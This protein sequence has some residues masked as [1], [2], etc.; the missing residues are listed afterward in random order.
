MDIEKHRNGGL[1]ADDL[2]SR[3]N[4]M[5]TIL[6]AVSSALLCVS[7]VPSTPQAR[8]QR[9]PEKFSALSAK[10]RGLVEQGK[11]ARGMPRDAVYLAWGSPSGV[12]QGT[13]ENKTTERWDYSGSRPVYMTGFYGGYGYGPYG[14]HGRY[15]YSGL[16][17]GLGPEVAYIPYRVASVWFL[18]NRVDAWERAR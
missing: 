3:L 16:G 5:K 17:F 9:N 12:F 7:C 15:G 1:R 6:A 10:D 13:R 18:D 14:Y 8:I 4:I 2:F 11:I